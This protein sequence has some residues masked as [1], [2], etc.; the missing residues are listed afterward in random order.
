LVGTLTSLGRQIASSQ[1][2]C[3]DSDGSAGKNPGIESEF[4]CVK[5]GYRPDLWFSFNIQIGS[6]HFHDDAHQ[7]NGENKRYEVEAQTTEDG[8]HHREDKA[9]ERGGNSAG[10]SGYHPRGGIQRTYLASSLQM[11]Q[12]RKVKNDK[13]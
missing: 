4:K 13:K 10:L 1:K 7:C 2:E 6:Y 12:I 3:L 5:A 11:Q 8:N 9:N